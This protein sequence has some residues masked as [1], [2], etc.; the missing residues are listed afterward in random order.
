M[1]TAILGIIVLVV[2][3]IVA[4]N[5]DG[6]GDSSSPEAATA[7]ATATGTAT[8]SPGATSPTAERSPSPGA[9]SP[10]ASPARSPSAEATPVS[11]TT[12]LQALIA[13]IQGKELT[14]ANCTYDQD[15]GEADCTADDHGVYWL[16]VP[17]EGTEA[18]CT[19]T[20]ADGVPAYLSCRTVEPLQA[21]IYEIG[22]QGGS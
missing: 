13:G 22:D 7:T 19:L 6:G 3:A 4:C 2:L 12:D 1:R 5:G 8:A 11:I 14:I 15:A 21:I 16:E 17:I 9:A 18:S 10:E 20:L